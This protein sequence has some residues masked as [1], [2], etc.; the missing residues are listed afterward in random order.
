MIET[1]FLGIGEVFNV[2]TLAIIVLGIFIG[3]LFGIIPG[4][5]GV[6][7]VALLLPFV[8]DMNPLTGIGFLL[9]ARAA[10][11]TGGAVSSILLG[12]PGTVSNSATVIDGHKL[13]KKGRGYIAVGAALSAS[14]IGGVIG[15]TTLAFSLPF[16]APVILSVGAPEVFILSSI[17]LLWIGLFGHKQ[18]KIKNFLMIFLGIGFSLVGYQRI[19]GEPRLYFG[20]DYLIDGIPI[21]PLVLG[22]F[23][24]PEIVTLLTKRVPEEAMKERKNRYFHELYLGL[25]ATLRRYLLVLKSSLL[26][27]GVGIIPGVGGETAP[28]L[29][30]ALAKK[31]RTF[32]ALDGVIAPESS[33]NAKEGGALIPTLALGIPGSAGMAMLLGAFMIL[34]VEPGPNFLVEHMNFAISLAFILA[35]ANIVAVLFMIALTPMVKKSISI[36]PHLLFIFLISCTVFGT[37]LSQ[38]NVFHIVFLVFFSFV[39]VI[40]DKLKVSKSALILGFIMG[41]LI[42]TYCIISIQAYGLALLSRPIVWLSLILL[43]WFFYKSSTLSK[44][45]K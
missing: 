31:A 37:Y 34:G 24:I 42:E 27:I 29:A 21:I 8:Y 38:K 17:G 32:S 4:L 33:N 7:T 13:Y 20:S 18:E 22:V 14:L 30:H 3:T 2:S 44:N 45:K 35:I 36:N 41:P 23:A 39:G 10:T 28:L 16:M 9:G 11:Y 12:I 15:A 25:F 40:I 1:V 5:S 43:L 26:G 19:S 6:T